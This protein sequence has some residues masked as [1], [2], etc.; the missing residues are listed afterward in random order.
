MTRNILLAAIKKK[1]LYIH[2]CSMCGYQCAF[3]YEG[4]QFGYDSGCDCTRWPTLW[5]PR[6]ES[7]LDFYLN[8]PSWKPILE[9]FIADASLEGPGT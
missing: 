3:Y 8:S 2:D 4:D 9:K 5:S 1:P 7:E 6:D